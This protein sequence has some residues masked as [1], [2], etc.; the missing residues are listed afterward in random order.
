MFNSTTP[1]ADNMIQA[2]P[3][4]QE[5]LITGQQPNPQHNFT[6]L[7]ELVTSHSPDGYEAFF[8]QVAELVSWQ[9]QDDKC[10]NA[11]VMKIMHELFRFRDAFREMRGGEAWG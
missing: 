3:A 6:P 8:N 5:L 4:L 1:N 2:T 11:Y 10:D 9:L 7:L